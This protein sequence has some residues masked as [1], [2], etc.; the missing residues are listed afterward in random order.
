MS[1]KW[2]E[3]GK[4]ILDSEDEIQ[5][6]YPIKM[7]G[8]YG[9]LIISSNRILFLQQIGFFQKD[10]SLIFDKQRE[11]IKQVNREGEYSFSILDKDGN[12]SKCEF[13]LSSDIICSYLTKWIDAPI[14]MNE[15]ESSIIHT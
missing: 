3:K 8:N 10:Y 1:K 13:E 9:W 5:K 6:S 12:V 15:P 14:L 11:E 4:K 2:Y 7:N